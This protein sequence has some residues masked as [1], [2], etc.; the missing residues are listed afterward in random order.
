M[1]NSYNDYHTDYIAEMTEP[2]KIVFLKIMAYLAACNHTLNSDEEKELQ[3]VAF[4]FNIP[5]SRLPEITTPTDAKTLIEEAKVITSRKVALHLIK[6]ACL[7][8][9]LDGDFSEDEISFI[10]NLGQ[11]LGIELEK[12]EQISQWVIDR[13]IW[14]EEEKII[15]ETN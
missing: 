15:F 2:Q 6:E 5:Q 10:G 12:V 8:A 13:L 14:L 9:N 11:A 7:L 1:S 3:D 4:L